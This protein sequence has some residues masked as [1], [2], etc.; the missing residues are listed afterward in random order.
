M[1]KGLIAG[2]GI[3]VIGAVFA[4]SGCTPT[5]PVDTPSVSWSI[6]NDQASITFTWDAIQDADGYIVKYNG[7]AD[8]IES[9]SYTIQEPTAEVEIVAYAGDNESDPWTASFA[10]V[11]TQ[12]LDWYT[13]ADT[14]PTH[15]SG[16]GFNND[17]SV[18]TIS[19]ANGNHNDIDFVADNDNSI[20]AIQA[21]DNSVAKNNGVA[22]N[23][24]YD[25][26]SMNEAPATGYTTYE[27]VVENGTFALLKDL[28]GQQNSNDI[29][30]KLLVKGVDG[31]RWTVDITVQPIGGLRWLVK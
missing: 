1:R 4:L 12:N 26:N 3:M 13:R 23:S 2:L 29:Y 8:T 28:D 24:S 9:T 19:Y 5:S 17:G 11:E 16:L 14:D 25:Y 30:A 31:T 27:P 18:V 22:Y 10:A 21:L 7:K 6:G 15:P 20:T